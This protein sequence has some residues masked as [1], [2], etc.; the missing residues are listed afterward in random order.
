MLAK[1]LSIGHA[2]VTDDQADPDAVIVALAI[3]NKATCELRFP[4]DKYDGFAILQLLE[5][6]TR[7][8]HN[9]FEADHGL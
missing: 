2:F 4:R 3:R 1:E 8:R 9:A 6:Q 7:P 5:Q